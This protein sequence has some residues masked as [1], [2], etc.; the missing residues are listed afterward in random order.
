MAEEQLSTTGERPRGVNSM[1][2]V[3]EVTCD[4][5]GRP[6]HHMD[7]YC[8]NTLECPL[9]GEALKTIPERDAHFSQQHP[10]EP[11]RGARYCLEDSIKAGF[12]KPG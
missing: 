9:C 12:L 10:H 5:C 3:G 1:L 2:S 4:K 8:Y 11:S 7:R 6:I